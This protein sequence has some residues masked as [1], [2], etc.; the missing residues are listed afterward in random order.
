MLW[1]TAA[2]E[3]SPQPFTVAG[4]RVL[5]LTG[6]VNRL[7]EQGLTMLRYPE[8]EQD[9][10]GVWTAPGGNRVVWFE[11]PDH[12]VLS[13]TQFEGAVVDEFWV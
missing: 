4:W 8:L 6:T 1:V 12:N 7:T 5:D 11:D 3:F 2:G 13:L 9:S 10:R